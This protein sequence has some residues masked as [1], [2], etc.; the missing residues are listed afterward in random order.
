METRLAEGPY[1]G[2]AKDS[3]LTM[4]GQRFALS[5]ALGLIAAA[6]HSVGA[7]AGGT[8][9]LIA[10]RQAVMRAMQA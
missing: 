3:V 7:G 5:F 8:D 6:G 10:Y 9:Q 1:R 4:N 2:Y